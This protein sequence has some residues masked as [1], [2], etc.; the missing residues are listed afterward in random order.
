MRQKPLK[1]LLIMYVPKNE[2]KIVFHSNDTSYE[3]MLGRKVVC[4]KNIYKFSIQHFLVGLIVF[5]LM[6]SSFIKSL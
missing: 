6:L 1:S 5:E 4:L 3:K 2:K